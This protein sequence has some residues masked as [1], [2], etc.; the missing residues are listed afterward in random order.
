MPS[1]RRGLPKGIRR[2]RN[3]RM[4]MNAFISRC[5]DK[6]QLPDLSKLSSI[7]DII[8]CDLGAE[9]HHV[10]GAVLDDKNNLYS[11]TLQ[12]DRWRGNNNTHQTVL[13][14][15][16]PHPNLQR[17]SIQNYIGGSIPDEWMITLTNLKRLHL[18]FCRNCEMLP[19]LGKLQSLETLELSSMTSVKKVGPEFLGLDQIDHNDLLLTLFPKLKRIQFLGMWSWCE[20]FGISGWKVNS[21]V[22]IMPRL[23]YLEFINSPKLESLPDF[24]QAAPIKHLIIK[25]CPQLE[26]C[27]QQDTGKE[28][29][30]IRHIPNI[31]GL[32]DDD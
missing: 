12:F 24:L 15:L 22:R 19:A 9:E 2:M 18:F 26:E 31:K 30:K 3:L 20:W 10:E 23:E 27:C 28:W 6:F 14:A 13:Q 21:L 7:G 29:D 32:P 1:D 8:V 4:L 11:L 17:L 25:G 5:S 16:K